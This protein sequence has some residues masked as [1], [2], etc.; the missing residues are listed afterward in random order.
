MMR[1]ASYQTTQAF[2]IDLREDELAEDLYRIYGRSGSVLGSVAA[3]GS[4]ASERRNPQRCK[5]L[6]NR[7]G[8]DRTYDQG[9]M[10]PLL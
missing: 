6:Q 5:G 8:R 4:G 1:H 9:I 10:S 7:P 2:Y 3:Q